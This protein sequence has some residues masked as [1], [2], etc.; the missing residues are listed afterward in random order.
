MKFRNL[1]FATSAFFALSTLM[2]LSSCGEDEK[3]LTFEDNP[4]EF[5]AANPSDEQCFGLDED[6]FC[7]ANPTSALCCIPT[8]DVVCFCETGTNGTDSPDCC[9]FDFQPECFCT[10]N[11][12]DA[13][14]AQDFGVGNGLGVVID[15]ENDL[16]SFAEDFFN[17]SGLVGFDGDANIKA[18]EGDHYLSLVIPVSDPDNRTWHDFKYWPTEKTGNEPSIDFSGM[19]NPTINMWVNSGSVAED[20]LGFTIAFWGREG[21][22]DSHDYPAH[23][24]FKVSTGG[25]WKLMSF[26]IKDMKVQDNWDGGSYDVD[27]TA[28]WSAIKFAFLPDTWHIAGDYTAHVDAISITDGPLNQLPWVK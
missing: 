13:Q 12:D 20:E 2:V 3:P 4:V 15:F 22:S 7:A 21:D 16:A 14:C 27:L 9:L 23:P 24:L 5:C 19:D 26:P 10:A 18:I 17:P 1:L 25:E 8:Q 6:A 28:K 11:P